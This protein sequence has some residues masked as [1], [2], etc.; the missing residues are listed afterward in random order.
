MSYDKVLG[1]R[2]IRYDPSTGLSSLFRLIPKRGARPELDVTYRLSNGDVL[3][4]SARE[5]LGV[6]EQTLLLIVLELAGEQYAH[7]GSDALL[8][9][10]DNRELPAKLWTGLYPHGGSGVR[11]TLKVDTTWDELN[12]RCGMGGN[13]GSAIA[14]RRRCMRRLCEV[15]VWEES[16]T[17]RTTQQSFLLVWVVGDDERIHLALNRRLAAAFLGGQYAKVSLAERLKLRRDTRMAMHAF[18]S[19]CIRPGH[20]LNIGLD[21][22]TSRLWPVDHDTAP[23]GTRRRRKSDVARGLEA[24]GRLTRWKVTMDAPR[25][26]ATV[27]REATGPARE[28]PF[29]PSTLKAT[30]EGER[31]TDKK[32]SQINDI[33]RSDVSGLFQ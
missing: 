11:Q 33:T 26:Q 6:Q 25:S 14:V 18:L 24:I 28:M 29:I 19:T 3:R 32:P 12:R 15:V 23:L 10:S 5:A 30:A 20:Q 1:P 17:R 21:K 4:F 16:G 13:G 9:D 8:T 31:A 2:V 7:E 22:L 27:Y